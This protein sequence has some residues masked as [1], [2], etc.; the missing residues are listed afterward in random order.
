MGPTGRRGT[1]TLAGV[2]IAAIVDARDAAGPDAQA[3]ADAIGAPHH[4]GRRVAQA[5]GRAR[6]TGIVL[7]DGTRIACDT[8]AVSGGWMPSLHLTGQSGGKPVWDATLA[9]FR[10][11][12]LPDNWDVAGSVTGALDLRAILAAGAQ[13]GSDAAGTGASA[14]PTAPSDLTADAPI[15]V[16]RVAGRGKAFVDLQHDVTAADIDL[17]QREG[18]EAVEHLKRY[19]TLGMATD[20]GKTSNLNGL[21][22]MAEL[23]GIDVPQ[24]GTTRYRPPY[25]PVALGTLAGAETGAHLAPTRH[26]PMHDWHVAHG[27]AMIAAGQWMRPRAYLRDSE[28]VRDAYIREAGAVRVGVGIVDVSTLGKIEVA[29][30]DAAE[31]LNRVYVNGWTKLA[32]GR[33]RYGV[34]L[35]DDGVVLDD[36][37][38][39]RLEEHRFL[40]TTT[41]ANAARVLSHLEILLATAWPDL[42][43]RVTSVT[44]QWA[45]MA[46]AGPRARDVLSAMMPDIAWDGEAFP[47]MGVRTGTCHGAPVT[48]ARLSFSGELAFE[49][50]CG[51]DHGADIWTAILEA[52]ND[53]GI[54]PYGTEALGTLRIEK[55]HVAGGELDGRTTLDDI[56][57]AGFA[58]TKKPFVGA[59]MR[60]RP[61]LTDAKRLRL[62]GLRSTDGTPIRPGAH[63]VGA[64]GASQGACH[65]HDPQPRNRG[66]DRIG[67]AVE[68]TEPDGG[69]FGCGLPPAGYYDPRR[70][71][72]PQLCRSRRDASSCLISP[73]RRPRPNGRC[74]VLPFRNDGAHRWCRLR[75]GPDGCTG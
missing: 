2:G 52:G 29:G 4:L 72:L 45:G 17:A 13:A 61:A 36:G 39:W 73:S 33:A 23:R 50:F 12:P 51:A 6:V 55:G 66:G 58:S 35:R 31:F 30:P 38:T 48:V 63:L 18:F 44:D 53:H 49:V 56:G 26:T 37:T 14:T 16:W 68:R 59:I 5:T 75:H 28:T 40:M 69:A 71:R 15:P 62:I 11:G 41:T 43:V 60:Q 7:D 1:C 47:F 10:P 27:G 46:V 67:D 8:L 65:R 74:R 70:D 64:D 42:R 20:Q 34:M 25:T 57:M 24:V 19:T 9:T 54:V 32:V 22:I 3:V 21:A